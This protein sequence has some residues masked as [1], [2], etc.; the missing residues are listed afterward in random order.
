MIY[1]IFE[2]FVIN[3]DLLMARRAIVETLHTSGASL[4]F[5]IIIIYVIF[6]M[7][8]CAIREPLHAFGAPYIHF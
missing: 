3:T 5:S 4:F 2:L 7:A 1:N 6:L 8:R